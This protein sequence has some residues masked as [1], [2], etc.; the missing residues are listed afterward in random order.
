MSGGE[1]EVRRG[2][3]KEIMGRKVE[4]RSGELV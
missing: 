1:E 3:V 4:V 2:E